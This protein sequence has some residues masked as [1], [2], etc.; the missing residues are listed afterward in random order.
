[1]GGCAAAVHINYKCEIPNTKKNVK[2]GTMIL[3]LLNN[4]ESSDTEYIVRNKKQIEN[5]KRTENEISK[6][7]D[8]ILDHGKTNKTPGRK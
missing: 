8:F 4:C 1:M 3:P 6:I 7:F 2:S 5:K